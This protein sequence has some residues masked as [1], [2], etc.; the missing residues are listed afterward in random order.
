MVGS[1]IDTV[2][3]VRRLCEQRLAHLVGA[4]VTRV[5]TTYMDEVLGVAIQLDGP[6]EWRHAVM[7]SMREA[8][9]DPVEFAD[10]VSDAL[11]EAIEARQKQ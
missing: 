6:P 4:K 8:R 11:I 7:G 9:S 3:Q 2:G 5:M 1:V 10:S